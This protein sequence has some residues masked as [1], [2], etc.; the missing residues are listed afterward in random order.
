MPGSSS[1]STEL[2]ICRFKDVTDSLS[3]LDLWSR[4]NPMN[5]LIPLLLVIAGFIATLLLDKSA[6]KYIALVAAILSLLEPL[7]TTT[8]PGLGFDLLLLLWPLLG[9]TLMWLLTLYLCRT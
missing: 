4:S 9:G 7:I 8:F 1:K 6:R 3:K 2:S 5:I